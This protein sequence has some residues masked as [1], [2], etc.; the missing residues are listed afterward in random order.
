MVGQSNTGAESTMPRKVV[1]VNNKTNKYTTNKNTQSSGNPLPA[2][3][4]SASAWSTMPTLSLGQ[5]WVNQTQTNKHM[6]IYTTDVMRSSCTSIL[7][8]HLLLAGETQTKH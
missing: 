6:Q 7:D 8:P 2:L 5:W 3:N 1:P 4:T